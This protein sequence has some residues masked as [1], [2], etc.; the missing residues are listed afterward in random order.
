MLLTD[1]AHRSDAV[2]LLQPV[3]KASDDDKQANDHELLSSLASSALGVDLTERS[4]Q[5]QPPPPPPLM[6]AERTEAAEPTRMDLPAGELL[7]SA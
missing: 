6:D 3:K 4:P 2:G 7:L 5:Q 1:P